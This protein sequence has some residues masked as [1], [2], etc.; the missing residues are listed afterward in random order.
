V[1]GVCNIKLDHNLGVLEVMPPQRTD[2]VLTTDIPHGE[3][4][5]LVLDGLDVETNSGDGG[6]DF[7]QL[8]LVQNCGLSGSVQTDHENAHLLL[9]PQL[10]EQLRECK[11]HVCGGVCGVLGRG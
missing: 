5:V 8:E 10:V 1:N 11:T 4:D 9:A 7:T 2:L 6:D 3:R